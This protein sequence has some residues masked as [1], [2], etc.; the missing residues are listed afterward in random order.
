LG[1]ILE[2]RGAIAIEVPRMREWRLDDG[3]SIA[4]H[5]AG[6]LLAVDKEEWR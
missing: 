3:V 6:A 5:E 4:V 1:A 2:D